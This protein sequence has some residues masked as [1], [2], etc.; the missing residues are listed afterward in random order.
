[1]DGRS[2]SDRFTGVSLNVRDFRFK[3]G[4]YAHA[5]VPNTSNDMTPRTS[6]VVLLVTKV[7]AIAIRL[8]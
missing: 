1:M 6:T 2:P 7:H 8:A 3:F 5:T 4:Q